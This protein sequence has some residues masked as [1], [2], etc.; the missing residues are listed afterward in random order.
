MKKK[1]TPKKKKII[2]HK[3]KSSK[4]RIINHKK[5]THPIKKKKTHITLK[6]KTHSKKPVNKKRKP[7]LIKKITKLFK[8]KIKIKKDLLKQR[9]IKEIEKIREQDLTPDTIEKINHVFRIFLNKKYSIKESLTPEE[10]KNQIKSKKIKKPKI[11]ILYTLIK[12][13]DIE[14]SGKIVSKQ[15]VNKLVKEVQSTIKES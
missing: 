3:K 1:T 7:G 8:P 5:K 2:Y 11:K 13:S 6:K 4:K 9:A 14:Y 12:L 10:V 15:E